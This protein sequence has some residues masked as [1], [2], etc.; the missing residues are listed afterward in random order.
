MS[1]VPATPID[2]MPP[3]RQAFERMRSAFHGD[4]APALAVR[5]DR[6]SRVARM[7]RRHAR[8]IIDA[9]SADFGHRSPH[10]TL[11]A[12]LLA[13]DEA[14]KHVRKHLQHV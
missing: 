9:I 14:I 5:R 13:V 1:A 2:P 11:I 7:T 10:E 6:L 12:D 8:D 4:M 3:L